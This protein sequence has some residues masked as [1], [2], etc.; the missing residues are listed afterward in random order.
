MR[1]MQPHPKSGIL[2]IMSYYP[3]RVVTK[4]Q[5]MS[6]NK[7]IKYKLVQPL[8]KTAQK[9]Q[10]KCKEDKTIIQYNKTLEI[11]E[12]CLLKGHL[13]SH[14]NCSSVLTV[15]PGVHGQVDR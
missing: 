9:F 4:R 15:N 3:V 10:K 2:F 12:I 14:A 6:S 7:G 5:N 1:E 13:C 11:I 8:W